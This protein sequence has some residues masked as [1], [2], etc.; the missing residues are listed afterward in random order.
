MGNS[1]SLKGLRNT[2]PKY[3]TEIGKYYYIHIFNI[4]CKE[5]DIRH[6]RYC[7]HDWICLHICNICTI[8]QIENPSNITWYIKGGFS[9]LPSFLIQAFFRTPFMHTMISFKAESEFFQLVLKKI[10]TNLV[11]A[12]TSNKNPKNLPKCFKRSWTVI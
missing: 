7:M 3:Q 5:L 4:D 1:E 12:Y 10:I 11:N 2:I 6:G 9:I 8:I